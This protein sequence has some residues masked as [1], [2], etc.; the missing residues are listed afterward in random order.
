MDSAA[1]TSTAAIIWLFICV[2]QTLAQPEDPSAHVGI[3]TCETS[4]NFGLVI[5]SRQR[6]GCRFV[7]DRGGTSQRYV[8]RVNMSKWA[9]GVFAW[10]VLDAMPDVPRGS[11]R[12]TYV[13]V[14]GQA[15]FGAGLGQNV[16]VGGPRH[17]VS[18]R[19]EAQVGSNMALGVSSLVLR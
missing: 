6:I 12:G 16:L 13:R 2:S 11:L 8:A 18:L 4:A 14:R 1:W 17:S 3:L 7:P 15:S 9:S 5:R 19:P 10:G